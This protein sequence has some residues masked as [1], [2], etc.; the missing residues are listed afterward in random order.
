MAQSMQ[1]SIFSAD[2]GTIW[3]E[4]Q[5]GQVKHIEVELFSEVVFEFFLNVR[6]PILG[7]Y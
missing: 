2:R 7:E 1:T 3:K 4:G 5:M 6:I